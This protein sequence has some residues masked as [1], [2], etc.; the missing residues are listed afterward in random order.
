MSVLKGI[1][2]F[3]VSVLFIISLY[4]TITSF[5]MIDLIQ[6]DN[7]KDFIQTQTTGKIISQSCDEYCNDEL[8]NQKCE[9]E[10]N[11]MGGVNECKK[12][13]LSET[14]RICVE[15]LSKSNES[16]QQIYN[17]IDEIYSNEIISGISLDNI[18]SI[19]RN[20]ILFIALTLIFGFLIFLVSDKPITKLGNSIIW[21]SISL[22]AMAV[23]PIFVITPDI[24]IIEMITSYV[25]EG[26]YQQLYFG[27][28]L[29][30]I[31][32]V[33]IVIGKKKGK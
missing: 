28:I 1:L 6:K 22:L 7:I 24:P 3:I 14:E 4:L 10:C 18:L 29:I 26:L 21:V 5:T 11:Y 12:I 8:N 25:L 30:I 33:L 13:C 15:C 9:E 19:F 27:I 17:T 32:I 20:T 31:G 16:Q 2:G 23:I